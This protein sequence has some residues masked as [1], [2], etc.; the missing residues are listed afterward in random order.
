[1]TDFKELK[2]KCDAILGPYKAKEAAF[3]AKQEQAVKILESLR[4]KVIAEGSYLSAAD[5][6][7][8]DVRI[9]NVCQFF[10]S[11]YLCKD[12]NDFYGTN[13]LGVYCSE[14][15]EDYSKNRLFAIPVTSDCVEKLD[16]YRKLEQSLVEDKADLELAQLKAARGE[17]EKILRAAL[18]LPE[19]VKAFATD[20]IADFKVVLTSDK[21]WHPCS[22]CDNMTIGR[23]IN[24][25][26]KSDEENSLLV[27]QVCGLILS[28]DKITGSCVIE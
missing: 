22:E 4:A 12:K 15:D 18:D 17:K 28:L 27:K 26:G 13:K 14:V 11:V 6:T 7:A 9:F 19:G 25:Q 21:S 5:V 16:S 10:P 20:D 23:V 3:L 1:M 24:F 8:R 2:S